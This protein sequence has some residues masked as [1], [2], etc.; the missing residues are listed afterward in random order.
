[1]P[2]IIS[3]EKHNGW[4]D[5]WRT[6]SGGGAKASYVRHIFNG[7]RYV[8]KERK[9]TSTLPAGIICLAGEFNYAS[10]IS[11]EPRN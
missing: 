9:A 2:V 11:L 4:H 8:E 6:E 7:K 5:I 3:T 1:M 10:G